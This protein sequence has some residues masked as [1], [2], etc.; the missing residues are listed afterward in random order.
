MASSCAANT[1]PSP[2]VPPPQLHNTPPPTQSHSIPPP[3]HHNPLSHQLPSSPMYNPVPSCPPFPCGN[4]GQL[5]HV[6]LTRTQYHFYPPPLGAVPWPAPPFPIFYPPAPISPHL[7]PPSCTNLQLPVNSSFNCNSFA[8]F[9]FRVLP[10]NL[11]PPNN[12]P[13]GLVNDL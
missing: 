7:Y 2:H 10:F 11:H 9:V 8:L 3:P 4:G 5:E 6:Y 12:G 1:M 13:I